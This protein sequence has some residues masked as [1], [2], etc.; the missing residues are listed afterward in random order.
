MRKKEEK[1]NFDLS[2]LDLH[3]LIKVYEEINE[4]LSFLND[5][6]IVIEEEDDKNE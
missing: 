5:N 2:N 1:I 3:E 6:K 4:F